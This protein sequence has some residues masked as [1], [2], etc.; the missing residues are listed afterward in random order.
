[1]LLHEGKAT[2]V[3][4]RDGREILCT[5]IISD[6]GAANTYGK[7][8]SCMTAQAAEVARIGPSAAHLSLY[9]GLDRSDRELGLRQ[10]NHW[11]Y[12]S[13]DHDGNVARFETDPE[14]PFPVVFL[15][16]PSTKDPTFGQRYPDKATCELV[17]PIPFRSFAK[18]G[19]TRWKRR[20]EDYDAVKQNLAQRLLHVLEARVPQV[21]GHVAWAELSTPLSTQHFANYEQGEI[22]GVSAVPARFRSKALWPATAMPGLYLTGQDAAM[23]GVTGAL[24]G[25]ALA[26]SVILRR[27]VLAKI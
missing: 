8:A 25:G 9:I 17:A 16:F 26:A 27:N 24:F 20:G 2:G 6:A 19:G 22:Y 21:R 7:L 4:M 5:T 23:L 18:W 12:P 11:I 13:A 3:R 15:S 10:T 14:Q 1:M